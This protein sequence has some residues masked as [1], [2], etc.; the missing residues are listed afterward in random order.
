M[1]NSKG[2]G[3]PLSFIVIAAISVLVLIIIIAVT[4]GPGGGL[5]K[6]LIAPA[7]TELGTV[8]VACNSFCERAR[9]TVQTQDQ[10]K[11]SDYCTKTY[12]IDIDKDGKI[13]TNAT[14]MPKEVGLHCVD[15]GMLCTVQSANG[16]LLTC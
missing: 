3:L 7:P 13:N 15:V 8:Q 14:A 9:V 10:Y 2:Q 12:A 11:D 4:L 16:T 5:L 6:Q 1:A